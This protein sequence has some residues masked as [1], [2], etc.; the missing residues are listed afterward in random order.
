MEVFQ[1][2]HF[3][4]LRCSVVRCS[5]YL[6]AEDDGRGVC[7]SGQRG[8]HNTVWAVE[9]ITGDVPGAAPGPYVRLR[10]A[11][12]RYLVATD[13][14]A[15]AGPA[16]GVTAEQRDAAHHPTPPPWAWQAFRRRS[17]SLL[18]N[19]TGRYLRANGRYLRWRTAVTVA[20]D[21]ASP[22]MLWAVEVVPPKPGRVT[23]VDR[24]AQ[25]IRRR[26]GPATE[27]ETSRVIR[28]VRGDEGG[29]FEE[30]E[31]RALRVNTNSLM[32]LRLTLANL[33]GHNRDALHTTVCVRAGAYAQLSP[34]L[35]DL[36]IGNDRIDVV[37]LSHGTPAEDA[38]KYPCVDA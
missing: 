2:A 23:L 28:F 26:R 25:L 19:G 21:N 17:S 37:V 6:A 33:L 27:G 31:W 1:D 3:V 9:H 29:E 36:P 13:L 8:A 34:L 15:K 24:P 12:G 38:L 35:V 7:L 22:M 11:Y 16:H 5:K 14:Q 18:R 32:H 10:G 20:G 30:S 4:R